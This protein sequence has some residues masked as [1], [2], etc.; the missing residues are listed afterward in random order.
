MAGALVL[1][2]LI[3][4]VVIGPAE[5]W[6]RIGIDWIEGLGA[7]GGVVFAGIYVVATVLFVPGLFLTIGAG[8]LF[9]V[10]WGTVVVS[11]ASTTGALLAFLIGRYLARDAVRDRVE[12]YPRFQAIYR[13]IGEDDFKV[14]LLTRLVP[15]F[16][17][18]LLNYAFG[19]TNVSWRR[20]VVASWLGMLPA[21]IAYVYAGAAA[22]T[23]ARGVAGAQPPAAATYALWGLGVVA[24]VAVITIITRRARRELEEIMAEEQLDVDED[25]DEVQ[26]IHDFKLPD[27]R[28]GE[29]VLSEVLSQGRVLLL[30]YRG[31]WCPLCNRQLQKLSEQ[32]E[33]FSERQV[34]VLAISNEAVE[35]GEK[36][37]RNIGPPYPLLLDTSS[38][39]LKELG[40]ITEKRDLWARVMRKHDFAHPAALLVDTDHRVQWSYRGRNYRDRRSVSTLLDAIDARSAAS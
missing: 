12:D 28:G 13:A 26:V 17:F 40:L 31:G 19:L 32:Y 4:A 21:T 15:L 22:G 8:I 33:A 35:Q 27:V 6:L 2:V 23:V 36:V 30:F 3:V 18:N 34:E 37:L 24:V 20:Y 10:V 11:A 7:V 5:A 1:V 25:A 39:T 29:V 38:E 14:V 16:P 9:G